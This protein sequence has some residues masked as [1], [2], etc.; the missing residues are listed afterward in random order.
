MN[1]F[2]VIIRS[3]YPTTK[4]VTWLTIVVMRVTRNHVKTTFSARVHTNSFLKG[5]TCDG[6][7]DCKFFD[8]ECNEE[9]NPSERQ[10]LGTLGLK[11]STWLIGTL[12]VVF[13]GY[14]IV[15]TMQTIKKNKSY[16]G[17]MN[18]VLIILVGFGDFLMG[19]YLI[20]IASIDQYYAEG[21]CKK[22][23]TWLTSAECM[24]LGAVNTVASQL[25]LFS[26]TALSVF[27]ISSIGQM[28]PKVW[29][30]SNRS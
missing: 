5:S 1:Y 26:M 6:F 25:S 20:S 24:A 8:D 14:T 7:Y 18:K 2:L 28:V 19:C 13:N 16:A 4:S 21:Y 15:R 11:V 29:E 3:V 23:F 9:C 12:A 27:R 17:I 10:I 30:V 22:K